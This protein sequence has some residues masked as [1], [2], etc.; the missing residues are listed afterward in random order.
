MGCDN[1]S[2]SYGIGKTSYL[3]RYADPKGYSNV[4]LLSNKQ[5]TEVDH[6]WTSS[7]G[8]CLWVSTGVC[9]CAK[10]ECA[11][12]FNHKVVTKSRYIPPDWLPPNANADTFHSHCV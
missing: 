7:Y 11:A 3:N 5:Y 1:T 6:S 9:V 2:R 12:Q 10:L 8:S 4:F